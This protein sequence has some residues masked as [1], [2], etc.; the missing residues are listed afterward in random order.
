MS[1]EIMNIKTPITNIKR[2]YIIFIILKIS[3]DT[4][5]GH[6]K[7]VVKLLIC[8]SSDTIHCMWISV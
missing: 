5:E 8:M 2:I 1:L 3:V 7:V 4:N 6:V